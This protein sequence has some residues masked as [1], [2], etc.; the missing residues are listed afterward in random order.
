VTAPP[1]GTPTVGS[2]PFA[3]AWFGCP[4][5]VIQEGFPSKRA[6][7]RAGHDHQ[8]GVTPEERERV[9]AIRY[10]DY[11]RHGG[12]RQGGPKGKHVRAC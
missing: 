4:C 3:G 12:P 9:H 2:D 11:M 8:H 5:G 10:A 1:C 6:A 7:K